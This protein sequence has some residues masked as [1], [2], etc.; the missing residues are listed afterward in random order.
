MGES[1]YQPP[2]Y[3]K[4][5]LKTEHDLNRG[6]A[7]GIYD[8]DLPMNVNI[9]TDWVCIGDPDEVGKAVEFINNCVAVIGDSGNFSSLRLKPASLPKL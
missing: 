2:S 9:K 6:L 5:V 4:G 8:L 1:N 7:Y 3:S